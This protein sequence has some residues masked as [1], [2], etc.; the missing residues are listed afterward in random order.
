MKSILILAI[1][2]VV[3]VLGL[4]GTMSSPTGYSVCESDEIAHVAFADNGMM[5]RS[6]MP[7]SILSETSTATIDLSQTGGRTITKTFRRGNTVR[8]FIRG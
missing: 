4:V 5:H 1:V 8:V 6:C 2:C 3:A 7:I